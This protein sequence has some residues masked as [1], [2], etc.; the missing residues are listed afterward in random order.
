MLKSVRATS[1]GGLTPYPDM[2]NRIMIF[3]SGG[4]A[5][6]IPAP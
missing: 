4:S 1:A 3:Q 6:V 2:K 5:V